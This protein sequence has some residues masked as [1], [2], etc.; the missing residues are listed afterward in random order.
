M[1]SKIGKLNKD[2]LQIQP[3][4]RDLY[5]KVDEIIDYLNSQ[6]EEKKTLKELEDDYLYSLRTANKP[7]SQNTHEGWIDEVTKVEVKDTPEEWDR[8]RRD[9]AL[10]FYIELEDWLYGKGY[11]KHREIKVPTEVFMRFVA[12]E[13]KFNSKKK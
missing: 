3:E 7:M 12:K 4:H 13:L 10:A 8:L 1:K 9:G 2:W 11:A 5:R 6:S